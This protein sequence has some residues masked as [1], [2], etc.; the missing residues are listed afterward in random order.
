M[1]SSVNGQW[2]LQ[3]MNYVLILHQL[4]SGEIT[5]LTV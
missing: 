3:D 4:F 2:S 5:E 1:T